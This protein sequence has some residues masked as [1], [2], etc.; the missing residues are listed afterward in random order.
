MLHVER[1]VEAICQSM[2]SKENYEEI[3][4]EL[5]ALRVI[6]SGFRLPPG[7]LREIRRS[8]QTV[9]LQYK[10]RFNALDGMN[11]VDR[12]NGSHENNISIILILTIP[13]TDETTPPPAKKLRK[14]PIGI[15]ILL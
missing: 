2:A 11:I 10:D 3:C 6:Q 13:I 14:S 15:Y 5:L 1:L 12:S 7:I 4:G 9:Y 8:L